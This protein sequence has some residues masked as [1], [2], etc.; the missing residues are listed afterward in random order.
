MTQTHRRELKQKIKNVCSL[1]LKDVVMT[2]ERAEAFIDALVDTMLEVKRGDVLDGLLH[3]GE[4]AKALGVDKVEEILD[5]LDRELS[6]NI[7]RTGANQSVARFILKMEKT[8][9]SLEDWI[10]WLKSE[11]WRLAHL[12][13]YAQNLEKIRIEWPQAFVKPVGDP[14]IKLWVD[15]KPVE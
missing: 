14:R 9:Q 1:Y 2:E 12:Y 10:R 15:G 13:I 3:Y 8:G 11:E 5:R 7:P 6:A 4:Q